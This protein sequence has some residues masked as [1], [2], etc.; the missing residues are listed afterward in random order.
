MLTIPEFLAACKEKRGKL[1][2]CPHCNVALFPIPLVVASRN[3]P[4]CGRRVVTEPEPS[5]DPPPFTSEQLD[6]ARDAECRLESRVAWFVLAAFV[7]W[8]G[9]PL[10]AALFR[11]TIHEALRPVMDPGWFFVLLM[12]VPLVV[13]ALMIYIWVLRAR[14]SAPK[15]PGC[16]AELTV[17]VRGRPHNPAWVVHLTGNCGSC[18]RGLIPPEE[19]VPVGTLPT[20]AEFKTSSAQLARGENRADLVFLGLMVG[21]FAGFLSLIA[22]VPNPQRLW[23]DFE[24]RYGLMATVA[25]QVGLAVVLTGTIAG[26]FAAGLY[27][28]GR[29]K[30]KLREADPLLTC[31]HC[32][33]ALTSSGLIIATKR[34]PNCRCRVLADVDGSGQRARCPMPTRSITLQKMTPNIN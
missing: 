34:C 1:P 29:R 25:V 15:C 23:F 22:S 31:P 14:R 11:D 24:N 3:C 20:V 30:R 26:L 19:D 8:M 13:A 10:V 33:A 32:R 9:C 4:G 7:V 17:I 5:S 28:I 2:C 18:G 27:F 16:G 12:T 21:G 6:A